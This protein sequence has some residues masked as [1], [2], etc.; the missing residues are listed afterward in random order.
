MRRSSR[1]DQAPNRGGASGRASPAAAGAT[2]SSRR[3]VFHKGDET[4][5]P[6]LSVHYVG[7]HT[8]GLQ[9]V[10]V[11][12]QRGWVV[13]ASD[14]AHYYANIEQS[15]PFPVVYNVGDMLEG[16]KRA[17]ALAD[18]PRNMIPSHDP[19]VLKR[20]P[21]PHHDLQGV[22]ARLDVDPVSE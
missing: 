16:H 8:M 3:A 11:W 18:S 4:L 15:R 21:T 17:Y 10:R 9:M 1:T 13:L 14:A 22:V 20:Y 19:L 7:G 6:G 2:S 5:A 12:T